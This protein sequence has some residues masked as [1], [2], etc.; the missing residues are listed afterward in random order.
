MLSGSEDW[1]TEPTLPP[2][3]TTQ[4]DTRHRRCFLLFPELR[5]LFTVAPVLMNHLLSVS[6]SMPVADLL[7]LCLSHLGPVG[8]LLLGRAA[9][10]QGDPAQ[11]LPGPHAAPPA[12]HRHHQRDL[13][14][15]EERHLEDKRLL[16]GGVRLAAAHGRLALGHLFALGVQHGQLNIGVCKERHAG[17]Q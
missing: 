1:E 6:E 12:E 3:C 7:P 15:L 4:K 10:A 9:V 5:V 14:E 13:G 8:L 16:V 11:P 2:E 17:D